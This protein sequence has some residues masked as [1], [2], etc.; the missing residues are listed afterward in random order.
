MSKLLSK[1]WSLTSFS[2]T[3]E[4]MARKMSPVDLIPLMAQT[5]LAD[6][7]ELDGPQFFRNYPDVG[8]SQLDLVKA[9]CEEQG[10]G[11]SIVGGYMDRFYGQAR[12]INQTL[13]MKR[14]EQQLQLAARLGA[15]GLRLQFD[16]LPEAE[17]DQAISWAEAYRVKILLELQGSATPDQPNIAK[18]VESVTSRA[19]PMFRI[20]IDTSLFMKSFPSTY[21]LKLQG[22]GLTTEILETLEAKWLAN[23][24]SEMRNWLIA[25]LQAGNLPGQ[26]ASQLPTLTS[27]FGHTKADDWAH[28]KPVLDSLHLKY[29]DA[30]DSNGALSG[31]A[32]EA[33]TL[34]ETTEFPGFIVSEWGGHDWIPLDVSTGVEMSERHKSALATT[35][36]AASQ[37][38]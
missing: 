37:S 24:S 32:R 14:L 33:L 5:G 15:H 17:I 21:K 10:I 27:R 23:T 8:Q 16:A 9:A 19:N 36:W 26:L 11:I 12:P 34:F 30:D 1:V 25:E 3:S 18:I 22:M 38:A 2:F 20:L 31:V 28:L 4:L 35:L 6:H 29:W 13:V 7:L